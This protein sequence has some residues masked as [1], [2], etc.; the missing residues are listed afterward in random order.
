MFENYLRT[1]RC[2]N[3]FTLTDPWCGWQDIGKSPGNWR[4]T[5]I[6]ALFDW[7]S[8]HWTSNQQISNRCICLRLP[9]FGKSTAILLL[10]QQEES[11]M[12]KHVRRAQKKSLRRML[13]RERTGGALAD[14]SFQLKQMIWGTCVP[15]AMLIS[16]RT[17]HGPAHSR[18]I[19]SFIPIINDYAP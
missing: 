12:Q 1:S 19:L 4:F 14:F 3:Y 10:Q 5:E 6:E 15:E 16:H 13:L 9:V 11:M 2:F 8:Y 7:S 17:N 18:V